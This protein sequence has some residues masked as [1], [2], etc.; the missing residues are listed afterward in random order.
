M[1]VDESLPDGS[2]RWERVA[3]SSAVSRRG[4]FRKGGRPSLPSFISFVVVLMVISCG[5]DEYQ[6]KDMDIWYAYLAALINEDE[7]DSIR[8]PLYN[9]RNLCGYPGIV[10]VLEPYAGALAVYVLRHRPRW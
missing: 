5:N 8:R 9:G 10:L 1:T 4:G 3:K 7:L 6:C 2:F